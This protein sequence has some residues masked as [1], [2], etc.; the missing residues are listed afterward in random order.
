MVTKINFFVHV[1]ANSL[2]DFD[3][4]LIQFLATFVDDLSLP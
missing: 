4:Q 1:Q 3:F 2:T